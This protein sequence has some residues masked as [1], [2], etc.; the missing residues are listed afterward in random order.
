MKNVQNKPHNKH[1]HKDWK[2]VLFITFVFIII[3]HYK[4]QIDLIL[5]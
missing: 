4:V 2:A 5:K 1:I 3:L